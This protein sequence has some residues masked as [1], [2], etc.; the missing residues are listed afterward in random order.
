[1]GNLKENFWGQKIQVV[2]FCNLSFPRS[3]EKYYKKSVEQQWFN[4]ISFQKPERVYP[5][6]RYDLKPFANMKGSSCLVQESRKVVKGQSTI[7]NQINYENHN[8]FASRN[9]ILPN[10]TMLMS[11][12]FIP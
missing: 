12:C 9:W 7:I 10:R 11:V 1:M 3:A 4:V 8:V 2:L 6:I 5:A